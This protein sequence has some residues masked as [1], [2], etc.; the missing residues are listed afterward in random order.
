MI[1]VHF[2]ENSFSLYWRIFV[3]LYAFISV[4]YEN[5]IFSFN[6]TKGPGGLFFFLEKNIPPKIYTIT[7]KA[8]VIT[9][10][11]FISYSKD[12]KIIVVIDYHINPS[13]PL[14]F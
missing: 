13:H 9:F 2:N 11:T 12:L 6:I 14:P 4:N 7:L 5:C 3:I 1:T 8:K 10:I